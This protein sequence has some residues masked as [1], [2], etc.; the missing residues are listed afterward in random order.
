MTADARDRRLKLSIRVEDEG[1]VVARVMRPLPIQVP[2]ARG[3]SL[4]PRRGTTN[5]VIILS[6][7]RYPV[8]HGRTST[9]SVAHLAKDY[10]WARAVAA[11]KHVRT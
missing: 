5:A 4:S 11:A 10:A 3:D 6:A 8:G 9:N 1:A 2:L 7:Y